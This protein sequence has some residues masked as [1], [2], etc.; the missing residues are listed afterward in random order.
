MDLQL[1]IK[2]IQCQCNE[3][4]QVHEA[5]K[6]FK[7]LWLLPISFVRRVGQGYWEGKKNVCIMCGVAKK[8]YMP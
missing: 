4:N 5:D 7:M 2:Y 1:Y 3:A 6:S 8:I